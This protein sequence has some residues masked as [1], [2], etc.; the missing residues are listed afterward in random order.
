MGTCQA[1]QN[2]GLDDAASQRMID[3]VC[4]GIKAPGR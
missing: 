4:D 3:I 1:A 2:S